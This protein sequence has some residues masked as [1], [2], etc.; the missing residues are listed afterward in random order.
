MKR[1]SCLLVGI[2]LMSTY[3]M[4]VQIDDFENYALGELGTV[5]SPPWTVLDNPEIPM[6]GAEEGGNQYQESTSA[7][8]NL[9]EGIAEGDVGTLFYR[10]FKPGAHNPDCSA[11]ISAAAQPGR[12]WGDFEAYCA[13]VGNEFRAR[14]AS[15]NTPVATLDDDTWYNVWLVIDN[16]S[17]TYDVY[18]TTGEADATESDQ[19][20]SDFSFRNGT[21]ADLVTFKIFGNANAAAPRA[22]YVDDIYIEQGVNLSLSIMQRNLGASRDPNPTDGQEDVL[23]DS[24]L[25]WTPGLY[26]VSHD[27]YLGTE[28]DDV[29]AASIANPMDVLVSTG[30]T[31]ATYVPGALEY[32]QTYY[33][34][35]DEVNK[36]SDNKIYT[37]DVWSF[38]VEPYLYQ[39]ADVNATASTTSDEDQQ[40]AKLVDGSGLTDG[41]H[42]TQESDMWV[43]SAVDG[44]P[45]S[46]Q[47]D[48]DR[49]YKI[50]NMH[51]WNYNFYLEPYIGLGV[52]D[53]T[54]EY[55]RDGAEWV[56]L[57]DFEVPQASGKADYAG[58]EIDFGGIAARS[59]RLLILSNR[60]GDDLFQYGL[61]EVQ[62]NYFPTFS[63]YPDPAEGATDVALDSLLSWRPGRSA[64]EFKVNLGTDPN[65]LA[66]VG[67]VQTETFSPGVLDLGSDYFWRIDDVNEAETPT[68]WMSNVWGFST[69]SYIVVDDFESYTDEP[70]EEVFTVWADGYGIGDNGSQVTYDNPPYMETT[71]VHGGEQSMPYYYGRDGAANSEA[72]MDVGGSNWTYGNAKTLVLYFHGDV[73]NDPAQLYVKI[74]TT[75]INYPGDSAG[76]AAPL[77]KQWNIDLAG[78]SASRVASF[79]IGVD[80]PGEGLLFIDD[81]RLYNEAPAM[82]GPAVDP[83]QDGLQAYY[84]MDNGLADASG[85]N[86]AGSA[87]DGVG[88]GDGPIGYGQAMT[89]DG[90]D[91]AYATIPVG[92][93]IEA[94][95]SMTIAAWVRRDATGQNQRIFDFGNDTD[96]YMFMSPSSGGVRFAITTG[97]Y[98]AESSIN[99]ANAIS[100]NSTW[101]HVAITIDG[102][103]AEMKL[104]VDGNLA[105]TELTETLPSDLGNT[106]NNWISRSQWSADPYLEGAI[107]EFRIYNRAL[108]DAEVR[109]LVGDR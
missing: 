84:P 107:D 97:S 15:S 17:D 100:S 20:A 109:Y 98:Q 54:V 43:G 27:V 83:G 29:N 13:I 23:R 74:G 63:R 68:T 56:T 81:I 90:T 41:V 79:T 49:D 61:S 39:I 62:F 82:P 60:G 2:M 103:A 58:T 40:P 67:T 86:R 37:G 45:V 85:N 19:V 80:G 25:T 38:T 35:V 70:G 28:F 16:G 95:D 3:A 7:Y 71:M 22:I 50:D 9:E 53:I 51:V 18:L 6:I 89:V 69:P 96:V 48:F 73:E 44:E 57:G 64:T 77:W 46:L 14:N 94:S 75:R 4:A 36:P 26:A 92:S 102:A 99:S 33:W 105:A 5:A 42:S 78:I 93:V 47:F 108:S 11:G 101:H 52:K 30:Q 32:G 88:F 10:V 34:R 8:I 21:N 59:V 106:A 55:T 1:L 104:Y 31:D 91:T 24:T 72:T 65:A 76:L 12:G 66:E 87:E